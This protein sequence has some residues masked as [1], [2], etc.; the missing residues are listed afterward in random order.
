MIIYNLSC[1]L[2]IYNLFNSFGSKHDSSVSIQAEEIALD[3]DAD[4]N[5]E[6]QPLATEVLH[7]TKTMKIASL[8]D[9]ITATLPHPPLSRRSF[10]FSQLDCL[11]HLKP[12]TVEQVFQYTVKHVIELLSCCDPK[13]LIKWCENLMASDTHEI[14]L[15]T[16]SFMDKIKQ[17]KTSAAILKMLSYYWTWSNYSALSVLA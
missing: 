2:A 4:N 12:S 11:K 16:P 9:S 6:Q 17:L 14:K 7:G 8:D 15:F 1:R 10:S 5:D 13:L 3:T